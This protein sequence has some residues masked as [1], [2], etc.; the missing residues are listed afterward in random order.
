MQDYRQFTKPAELHKAVNTLK[1][2]IAGITTDNVAS[3]KE[4]MELLHW[5]TL[6]AHLRDRHPFNELLPLVE[7]AYADGVVT[8]EEAKDIVWLC[9]NFVSD[10]DYYDLVTSS[11][12]FLS[13]LLHG[14][15]ADGVLDDSEV[16][17]L[18][19]WLNANRYLKGCYPFDEI[20]SLVTSALADKKIDQ[21]ERERMMAYF[22][23]FIDF[24]ESYNLDERKL[25]EMKQQYS[26]EGICAVCPEITIE[27]HYFCFTG[28]S[29]KYKRAEIFEI[30]DAAGGNNQGTVNRHT[31]YVVVGGAGN[32]CWAYACYGRKI[33]QAVKLR[34]AGSR[35]SIIHE[36]DLWD[37]LDD[38]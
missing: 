23:N 27:D 21:E 6:H 12:Q 20:D 30:I 9:N 13:G 33:E 38:L 1:G 14:I 28:E 2:I 26:V 19:T 11:V 7:E 16:R 31:N 35:L 22:S 17:A 15:M 5:C 29:R 3:E 25:A 34:K 36:N 10:S 32:P 37:A 8:G 18:S 24:T 4:M